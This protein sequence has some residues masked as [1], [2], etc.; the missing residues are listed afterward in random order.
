MELYGGDH[1]H[2]SIYGTYLATCVIYATIYGRNPSGV[3]Y[4]PVTATHPRVTLT[5]EEAEFLQAIAWHTV[6]DYRVGRV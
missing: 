4:L 6:Q 5:L 2:P 3:T 1:E